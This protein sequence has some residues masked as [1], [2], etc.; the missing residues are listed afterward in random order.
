MRFT[1]IIATP[2]AILRRILGL[3]LLAIGILGLLLPVLPGWPFIIPAIVL[4]GRRDPLL[5]RTHLVV[6]HALRWLR[7]HSHPCVRRL[8]MRL[9][10]EYVRTRTIVLPAIDKTERF[11]ATLSRRHEDT[12]ARST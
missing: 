3:L 8:G 4:L 1:S 12:K 9:T 11:W 10:V 2:L 6:R 5:R 7:R